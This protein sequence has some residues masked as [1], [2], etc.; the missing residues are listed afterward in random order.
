MVI[1]NDTDDAK[2][3]DDG[4]STVSKLSLLIIKT[5]QQPMPRH[6]NSFTC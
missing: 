4:K 3:T 1:L 6:C 5:L 2:D